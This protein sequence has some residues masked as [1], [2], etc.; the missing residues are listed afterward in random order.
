MLLLDSMS[1]SPQMIPHTEFNKQH[2]VVAP[3][4]NDTYVIKVMRLML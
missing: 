3:V 2:T 4:T 1:K